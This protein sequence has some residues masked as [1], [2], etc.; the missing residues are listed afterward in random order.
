MYPY[1]AHGYSFALLCAVLSI[2]FLNKD[3]SAKNIILAIM[4]IIATLASYQAYFCVITTL[5]LITYI[6]KLVNEK[7]SLKDV[8]IDVITL[9]LGMILYYVFLTIVLKV[10]NLDMSNY[11][12]GD[13]ILSL[14]T[15]KNIIPTIKNTYIRFYQFYF[16]DEIL[17][18]IS[19]HRNILNVV[20]FVAIIINFIIII[21]NN[22]IYKTPSKLILMCLMI[23]V[24][25]ICTCSIE[26][27]AQS[28]MVN[29]LMASALYL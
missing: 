27:I 25:P 21:I 12:G 26:L 1:T 11:S 29:L 23:L 6:F 16:T 22:K 2:Y 5:L 18:N 3:K 13:S 19:W 14:E 15:I 20:L 10:L 24:F 4:F 8:I 9:I 17:N 7:I 28:R